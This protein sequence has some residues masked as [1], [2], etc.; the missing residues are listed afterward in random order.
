MKNRILLAMIIL[1]FLPHYVVWG[2]VLISGFSVDYKST[3]NH[4]GFW[5][6]ACLWWL[7]GGIV[8]VAVAT[9]ES[10]ELKLPK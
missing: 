10:K 6:C 1:L 9:S 2:T 7:L 3:F 4:D 8:I 5:A